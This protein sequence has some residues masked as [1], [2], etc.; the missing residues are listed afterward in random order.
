[1]DKGNIIPLFHSDNELDEPMLFSNSPTH[2]E[3]TEPQ[4]GTFFEDEFILNS[5]H[6]IGQQAAKS[7]SEFR[8]TTTPPNLDR[9]VPTYAAKTA[10]PT[11]SARE[12]VSSE[13]ES[14]SSLLILPESGNKAHIPGTRD[15]HQ[16]CTDNSP[17]SSENFAGSRLNPS[18]PCFPPVTTS[19]TDKQTLYNIIDER[20]K[21]LLSSKDSSCNNLDSQVRETDSL[22]LEPTENTSKPK[23]NW[24]EFV[25][26]MA[27]SLNITCE[28]K[29]KQAEKSYMKEHFLIKKE[30]ENIDLPLEGSI[31]QTLKDIDQEWIDNNRIRH[32]KYKES[33]KYSI[34]EEHFYNFC[35]S[36]VLDENIDEGVMSSRNKTKSS[37][38]RLASTTNA[39]LHN[40]DKGAR[41]LIKQISYGTLMTSYLDQLRSDIDRQ[42]VIKNLY[43]L[44]LAMADLTGRICISSVTTRRSLQLKD[45]NFKNKVTE[46][47]LLKLS[48]LG[49]NIFVENVS[50]YYMAAQKI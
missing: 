34:F 4:E 30:T 19:I 15:V 26:K 17:I 32:F 9:S 1:M 18:E 29:T 20:L 16:S 41:L 27:T 5:N 13:N 14:I 44:F 49:P 33:R 25:S 11:V 10:Q 22:C 48:A 21:M 31:I 8:Q 36:P 6:T 39:C 45:M 2:S 50:K 47:K 35:K 28:N 42:E 3:F 23:S 24:N 46:R 40:L 7:R 12:T 37:T 38:D 43:E